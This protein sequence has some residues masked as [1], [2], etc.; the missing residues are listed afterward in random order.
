MATMREASARHKL[1]TGAR[2]HD[3]LSAGASDWHFRAAFDARRQMMKL[4][5][6][7]A[8]RRA[9]AMKLDTRRRLRAHAVFEAQREGAAAGDAA[10]IAADGH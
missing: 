7:A 6:I 5:A 2:G 3:A 4:A 9:I 10:V 8:P 1:G